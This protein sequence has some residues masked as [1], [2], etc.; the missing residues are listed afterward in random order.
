[1]SVTLVCSTTVVQS[2]VN[3]SVTGSNPVRPVGLCTQAATR[4]VCKTLVNRLRGFESLRNHFSH[5]STV[6]VHRICNARVMSSNLIDGF[7]GPVV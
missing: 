4:R 3:G 1:M 2:A 7:H 5:L 6:V